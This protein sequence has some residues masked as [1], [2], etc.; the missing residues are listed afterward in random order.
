ML[1]YADG[2]GCAAQG[3]SRVLRIALTDAVNGHKKTTVAA[4]YAKFY[5]LVI[6]DDYGAHIKAVRSYGSEYEYVR[7]WIDDGTTSTE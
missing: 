3:E 6:G 5:G 7:L 4:F 2:V 1:Y